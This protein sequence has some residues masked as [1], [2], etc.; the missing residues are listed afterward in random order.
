MAMIQGLR[1]PVQ[2]LR[3]LTDPI[4]PG[5]ERLAISCPRPSLGLVSPH[6]ILP[7][8]LGVKEK[9]LLLPQSAYMVKG[10]TRAMCCLSILLCSFEV[11]AF[12]EACVVL[13]VFLYPL[14]AWPPELQQPL[15]R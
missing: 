9:S 6:E 1:A 8:Q 3:M 14:K 4:V 10:W 13:G 12:L 11:T 15:G 5:V 7:H 2:F